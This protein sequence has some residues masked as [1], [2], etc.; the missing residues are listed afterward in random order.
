MNEAASSGTRRAGLVLAALGVVY[1]DIGTSPLYAIRECFHG[2]H[3]IPATPAHVLGVLSLI[4]WSLLLI[5]SLKYLVFVL[6]ADNRGEGG[7]LALMALAVPDR[8]DRGRRT[9]TAAGAG[10]LRGR[11]ALWRW[12]HHAILDGLER[13]GGAE[14]GNTRL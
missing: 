1:G 5:V 9:T 8:A 14:C 2:P 11:V 6:R 7:I 13:G 10:D 3:A 4:L 12:N